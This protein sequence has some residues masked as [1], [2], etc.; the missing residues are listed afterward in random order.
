M[1]HILV[2]AGPAPSAARF[3]LGWRPRARKSA[4]WRATL[5]R[6]VCHHRSRWFAK[7]SLFPGPLMDASMASMRCSWCGPLRPPLLLQRWNGPRSTHGA[8]YSS[9]LRT[10]RPTRSS[11]R[12]IRSER[13]SSKSSG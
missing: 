12:P 1:N 4:R 2:I 6:L 13:W 10:K 11:N 5:A 9:Q 3:C 7:I 8:S